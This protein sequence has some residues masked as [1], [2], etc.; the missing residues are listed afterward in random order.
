MSDQTTLVML[1]GWGSSASIWDQVANDLP[2]EIEILRPELPGHGAS[3]LMPGDLSDVA[4]QI[5]MEVNNRTDRPAWL[6]GWSLGAMVAMNI[7]FRSLSQVAGLLLV[8]ATPCF[9]Q[10]AGW[11]S[12]MPGAEM[13]AFIGEFELQPEKTLK[14]FS[15]LQ[16]KQDKKSREVIRQL[17]LAQKNA[18]QKMKWGLEVLKNSDLRQQV[19]SIRV[20]IFLLHGSYDA[21]VP[22]TVVHPFEVMT[23]ASSE[24]W[25][26]TGHVPFLSQPGRFVHWVRERLL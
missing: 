18:N 24:I 6:L 25:D 10:R 4:Q 20:P 3:R 16:A 13:D 7:A 15:A 22:A 21:V 14:R 1:H 2:G 9:I 19:A 17:R 8:G 12:A 5:A 26:G 23:K 11:S